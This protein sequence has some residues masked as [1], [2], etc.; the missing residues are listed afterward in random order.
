MT[1]IMIIKGGDSMVALNRG[2]CDSIDQKKHNN[3]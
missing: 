1:H 3:P 2:T